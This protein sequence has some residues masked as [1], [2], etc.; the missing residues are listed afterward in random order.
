MAAQSYLVGP[1]E[2][3]LSPLMPK[4]RRT[5]ARRHSED[6]IMKFGKFLLFALTLSLG[7]GT[8]FGQAIDLFT[9]LAGTAC[10]ANM[11][12]GTTPSLFI[13]ARTGGLA[14]D[15]LTG[16]EFWIQNWPTGWLTVVTPNPASGVAIGNPFATAEPFR[17]NIAFPT[18]QAG[19][20]VLLYSVTVIPTSIVPATHLKVVVAN[21]PSNVVY[22]T[23]IFTLCDPPLFTAIPVAGGEFFI[24]D[25][26]GRCAVGV[27]EA[28]WS[29]VKGLYH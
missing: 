5:Q 26:P 20:M 1:R 16:A 3:Q 15:G 2:P 7:V 21:P 25:T 8:A 17:A 24:N 18:C 19:P 4:V 11:A 13:Q 28:T 9:D 22:T 12:P 14:A 10:E 29:Q 23:P 27:E 6:A